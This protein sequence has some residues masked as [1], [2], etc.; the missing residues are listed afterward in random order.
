MKSAVTGKKKIYKLLFNPEHLH[1]L[2]SISKYW[3]FF[4]LDAPDLLIN[5]P[6][7]TDVVL[8]NQMQ[9]CTL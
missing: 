5:T 2:L 4:Y 8:Q 1:V 7:I 3:I 6:L 9:K